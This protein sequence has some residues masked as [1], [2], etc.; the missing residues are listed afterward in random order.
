MNLRTTALLGAG[1]VAIAALAA[2]G[3][4][5]AAQAGQPHMQNALADLEAAKRE[6]QVALPDKG[7]HRV[8]AIRLTDQAITETEAGMSVASGM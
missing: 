5:T 8:T 1:A 6:L 4:F 3:G 7:G 2:L